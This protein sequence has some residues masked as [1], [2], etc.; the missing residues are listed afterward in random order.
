MDR[1]DITEVTDFLQNGILTT[2]IV[3]FGHGMTCQIQLRG[4]GHCQSPLNFQI[5]RT[6]ST[7]NS[8]CSSSK[9][10]CQNGSE[11]LKPL[12]TS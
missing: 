6:F 5:E 2:P 7:L 1:I 4:L 10:I 3:C 11:H 8:R 12:G 9:R